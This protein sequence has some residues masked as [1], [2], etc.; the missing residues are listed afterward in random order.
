MKKKNL[1]LVYR[2]IKRILLNKP[3]TESEN[4]RK[5]EEEGGDHGSRPEILESVIEGTLCYLREWWEKDIGGRGCVK[6]GMSLLRRLRV[7]IRSDNYEIRKDALEAC[8]SF[9][10]L[11]GSGRELFFPPIVDSEGRKKKDSTPS[12]YVDSAAYVDLA[13]DWEKMKKRTFRCLRNIP[14]SYYRGRTAP[15]YHF[16][17]E[18]QGVLRKA[19]EYRLEAGQWAEG[20]WAAPIRNFQFPSWLGRLKVFI[21]K[22]DSWLR[23][24]EVVITLMGMDKDTRWTDI[25]QG[26]S[27]LRYDLEKWRAKARRRLVGACDRGS[28]EDPTS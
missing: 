28:E 16:S 4:I 7:E 14:R 6:I 15:F 25:H 13:E 5:E 9:L 2:G 27:R 17:Q 18:V 10:V 24:W 26:T 19:K 23:A 22:W 3:K 12:S 21:E 20:V 1:S 11:P 8:K